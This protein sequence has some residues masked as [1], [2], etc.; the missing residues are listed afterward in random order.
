VD[1]Q[2][3]VIKDRYIVSTLLGEGGDAIVYRAWDRALRRMVALKL[4]RPE[5]RADPTFVTRFEREARNTGRLNHP[6]IVPVYDY[7]EAV[8]TY[9]LIMEYVAG[10]D[11]RARL[12]PGE[13]LPLAFALRLA[14][15]VAEALGA[16]HASGIVHRD[17]KPP[18]I[19]LGVNDHAKVTD[20]GIAKMLDVPALTAATALLGTPHYLAPEVA[21]GAGITPATDVYALGVV[22]YEML[23]GRRPF[24]GESFVHVA[25]QHLHAQP[26]WLVE[27]NPAVPRDVAALVL[28]MLAKNPA[29]RFADGAALA[30]A[31]RAQASALGLG[32]PDDAARGRRIGAARPVATVTSV[33]THVAN[34]STVPPRAALP[35]GAA[36]APAASPAPT[37]TKPAS[38][39][40]K[41]AAAPSLPPAPP[42]AAEWAKPAPKSHPATATPGPGTPAATP[43][44]APGLRSRTLSARRPSL[45]PLLS[46]GMGAAQR[47]A[48][49]ARA[50][51]GAVRVPRR[52][53]QQPRQQAPTAAPIA[54][55]EP[56]Q[57]LAAPRPSVLGR[58]LR[59]ARYAYSRDRYATAAVLAV[60]LGMAAMGLVG[61]GTL[62]G[63][64]P[65]A[66]DAASHLAAPTAPAHQADLASSIAKGPLMPGAAPSA[67]PS[68]ASDPPPA[69]AAVEPPAAAVDNEKPELALPTV[70]SAEASVAPE[71]EPPAAAP[72]PA[73]AAPAPAAAPA[74]AAPAPA[75]VRVAAV[76]APA[77]APEPPPPPAPVQ[78]APAPAPEPPVA[79]A[80]PPEPPPAPAR[81]AARSAGRAQPQPQPQ[82]QPH[83]PYGP[84]GPPGPMPWAPY[85]PGP[86][87]PVAGYPVP[88]H[89]G[90]MPP[91]MVPPGMVP[92]GPVPPM[93]A[94]GAP[95][96][97]PPQWAHPANGRGNGNANGHQ[98][99]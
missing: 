31:L 50:A 34:I 18:N 37:R 84:G 98:R 58:G 20:F 56:A 94:P 65:T 73:P 42:L 60:G 4:L 76:A 41:V 70:A 96:Q 49:Q 25:M 83:P 21:T 3:R 82:P 40:R 86:L 81:P 93:A 32:D 59:H 57:P 69:P 2:D 26:Q 19:L 24:E 79:A 66:P 77:P 33:A 85:P 87:P 89:P 91:G 64:M 53:G 7:G 36:P 55:V 71:P 5:L 14:A 30:V 46:A 11:L 35:A 47:V 62:L 9:F 12:R 44:T 72:A 92:M 38:K 90:M 8:G 75:P 28:R 23:A 68:P 22:L 95:G 45:L 61:G 74:R 99:R 63:G 67:P 1:L 6:H 39:R 88:M 80:A 48:A 29:V 43:R 13:P 15:E 52:I 10:G 27:L 51:A 16:A 17:V 97:V 54:V 78:S